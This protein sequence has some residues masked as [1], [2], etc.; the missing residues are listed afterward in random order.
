MLG[1]SLCCRLREWSAAAD[2][3]N[4]AIRLNHVSLT[5]E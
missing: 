1:K 2:R 5:T 4:T 3:G